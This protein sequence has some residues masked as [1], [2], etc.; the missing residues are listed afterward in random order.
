MEKKVM[1]PEG[2]RLTVQTVL[3]D[4]TAKKREELEHLLDAMEGLGM[5]GLELNL[6]DLWDTI[7]PAEL[8][9]LLEQRGLKLTYVASGV[10]AGKRELSLASAREEIRQAS[11]RGLLENMRYA[12]EMGPET[13]VIIGTLKGAPAITQAEGAKERLVESLKEAA[14]LAQKEGLTVPVLLEATN[15]YE[16][17]VVNTLEEGRRVIEAVGWNE[18]GLL[19]DLYHMNIEEK[20]GREAITQSLPLLRNIHLSDNNRYF[21]GFGA[22]DFGAWYRFLSGIGYTG[23]FGIEGRIREGWIRD[24]EESAHFLS[25]AL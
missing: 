18:L 1:L 17:A 3:E 14:E 21:P 19:P 10:Y 8:G 4:K 2:M 7:S 15:H 5:Y 22:L 6:P 13:G 23:T 9:R 11:I 20:D 16:A 25:E 24:L 12:K